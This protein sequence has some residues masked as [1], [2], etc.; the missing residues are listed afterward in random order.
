MML[1]VSSTYYYIL[2]VGDYL[3]YIL[4]LVYLGGLLVLLIYIIMV[5]GNFRGLLAEAPNLFF[6]RGV[7]GFG[8]SFL[9]V[10]NPTREYKTVLSNSTFIINLSCVVLLVIFLL[11][12]F[13]NICFLVLIGGRRLNLNAKT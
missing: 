10:R 3:T 1:I 4:F 8:V 7:I 9:C 11:Y 5:A 13:L 12:V 6:A 2:F